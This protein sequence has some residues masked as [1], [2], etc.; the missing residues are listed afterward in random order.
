MKSVE[1]KLYQLPASDPHCFRPL[2]DRDIRDLSRYKLAYEGTVDDND[3][4]TDLAICEHLF[5]IHNRDDRP[6]PLA[7]RSLSMS[8]IVV[9]YDGKD[10]RC[11]YCDTYGFKP[12]P[13][14]KA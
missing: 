6:N 2:G 1:Y 9:L 8:D 4:A 13:D 7:G 3:T 14:C 11:F 10:G 12:L 5:I